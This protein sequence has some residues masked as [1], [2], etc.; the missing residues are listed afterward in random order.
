MQLLDGTNS[1]RLSCTSKYWIP[2]LPK[3]TSYFPTTGAKLH[4]GLFMKGKGA[5]E[6]VRVGQRVPLPGSQLPNGAQNYKHKTHPSHNKKIIIT[7]S[8]RGARP[9]LTS[10]ETSK[11]TEPQRQW[12]EAGE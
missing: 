8:R 12:W 5:K 1:N 3:K 9:K 10:S 2:F 7:S 6:R 11:R 4:S